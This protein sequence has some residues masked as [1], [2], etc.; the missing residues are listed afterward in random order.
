M[1]AYGFSHTAP[2]KVLVHL[3]QIGVPR[4]QIAILGPDY[5]ARKH[6]IFLDAMSFETYRERADKDQCICYVCDD[7]ISLAPFE[8]IPVDYKEADYFH[9]DGFTLTEFKSIPPAKQVTGRRRKFDVVDFAKDHAARQQTFFTNF[10]TFIYSMPS[11]T[12]QLPVRQL[13]CKWLASTETYRQLNNRIEK[14][15]KTVYLTDKQAERLVELLSTDIV[16]VYR[17]A[18][19]MD[20]EEDEVAHKLKISAYEMRYIRAINKGAAEQ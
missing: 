20:G 19:Q 8:L 14:L 11:E 9:V 17:T 18:L 1:I 16:D 10:M 2:D 3:R 5:E 15:R 12:H 4:A 6:L 13:A 7:P